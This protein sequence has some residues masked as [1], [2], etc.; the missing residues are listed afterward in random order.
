MERN[1]TFSCRIL[2]KL[3]I[4]LSHVLILSLS[5]SQLWAQETFTERLQERV[6]GQGVVR[7]YHDAE[8][9]TL[10]NGKRPATPTNTNMTGAR[11]LGN[12]LTQVHDSLL[13]IDTIATPGRKV[14]MTGYR[15][16][17]YAGGNSRDAKAK[18]Y[19]MERLARLYF[20]E[21]SVYT[22]FVSPR[23]ICH[24]G[25]FRTREEAVELLQEMRKSGKFPE[26][27]T[28]KCKIN[29]IIYE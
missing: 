25:D 28:V 1:H 14:R 15:V 19:Q 2:S 27:I 24:V 17:V 3:F 5:P 22:R 13:P 6:Q 8:I 7:L 4:L 20:P 23:W 9:A 29:F 11:P 12:Y 16:Q 26:A 10:V 18:A 21:H